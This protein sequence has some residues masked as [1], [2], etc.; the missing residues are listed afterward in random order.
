MHFAKSHLN[1][2]LI[3]PA[4]A[5]SGTAQQFSLWAAD[6]NPTVS[7]LT[8]LAAHGCISPAPAPSSHAG[9]AFLWAPTHHGKLSCT[10]A[11]AP[12]RWKD[13]IR[14][15][16]PCKWPSCVQTLP[17]DKMKLPRGGLVVLLT[18]WQGW[19]FSAHPP[20][21]IL[22]S[23]PNASLG[24]QLSLEPLKKNMGKTFFF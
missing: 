2:L 18:R 10:C 22:T 19:I 12:A 23:F 1:M 16:A 4:C 5:C 13:L 11:A 20:T 3:N 8:P 9:C 24:V 6:P 17:A 21:V 7:P 14:G 15:M